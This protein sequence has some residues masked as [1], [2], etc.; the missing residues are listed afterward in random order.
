MY[1][2]HNIIRPVSLYKKCLHL[3]TN[4]NYEYHFQINAGKGTFINGVTALGGGG[5]MDFVTRVLKH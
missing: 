3:W 1:R 5:V 2:R 4:C